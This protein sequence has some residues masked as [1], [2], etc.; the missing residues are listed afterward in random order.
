[1]DG[2]LGI[3]WDMD[4]VLV[5]TGQFH[6]QSWMSTLSEYGFSFSYEKFRVVFGMNN[7]STLHLILGEN[8]TNDLYLEISERK[9][10]NFRNAIQ[11]KV[12]LLPG[13]LPLLDS[14][15]LEN[16]PQA[17]VSSA[18]KANID[19]IVSE[20]DLESFFQTIISACE[21]P[22]KPDP[23]AFLTAA[24]RLDVLP[25]KCIVVEDA[26]AGVEAARRAGMKCVAVTTTHPAANL[27]SADL[28]VDRLD[29]ITVA[30]LT[31]LI[32]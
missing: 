9:E 23:T 29:S 24:R 27:Q 4:G 8:F 3:L 1:M 32:E 13:V 21:M 5:D 20:L 7:E 11:G 26:T 28:V 16:I 19:A 10:A 22:S 31:A 18:P 12:Q 6:F 25:G 14:V 2:K 30:D 17:I 15:N